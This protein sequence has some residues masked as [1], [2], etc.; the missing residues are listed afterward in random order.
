MQLGTGVTAGSLTP[1]QASAL[2][3]ADPPRHDGYLA[4]GGRFTCSARVADQT[5]KCGGENLDQQVAIPASATVDQADVTP[6]GPLVQVSLGEAHG[7]AVVDVAPAAPPQLT[8]KCWGRN[9][10]GQ[11]GRVTSGGAP[12]GLPASIGP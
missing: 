8:V 11:L 12:D 9:A 3:N 1:V 10:E 7:C 6:G 5:L 2:D 4:A